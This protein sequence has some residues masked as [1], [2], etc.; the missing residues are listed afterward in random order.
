[1]YQALDK[2]I[3]YELFNMHENIFATIKGKT[4]KRSYF[5]QYA[6]KYFNYFLL[7]V[8]KVFNAIN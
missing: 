3:G 2:V 5:H 8:Q 6:K 4:E 7:K 1:M